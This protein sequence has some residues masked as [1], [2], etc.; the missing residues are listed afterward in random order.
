M[1]GILSL[2]GEKH[3][4]GCG[5]LRKVFPI[6]RVK[7][8]IETTGINK[9]KWPRQ[10]KSWKIYIY[11]TTI[12]WNFLKQKKLGAKKPGNNTVFHL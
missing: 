9:K 1:L 11:V 10:F 5:S 4:Q 6:S 7:E 3:V 8:A 2:G 12:F